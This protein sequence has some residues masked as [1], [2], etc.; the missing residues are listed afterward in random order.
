LALMSVAEHELTREGVFLSKEAFE[1]SFGKGYRSY[2]EAVG[3]YEMVAL[4]LQG[5]PSMQ[6]DLRY[7][8]ALRSYKQMIAEDLASN[9][10]LQ[11]YLQRANQ[12]AG[13]AKIDPEVILASAYDYTNARWKADGWKAA[14]AKARMLKTKLDEGADWGDTLEL[15]S[16]FWDPPMPE[17]GQKP[18][19]GFNFKGRFGSH[20]RNQFVG[21]LSES[22][23][24]TFTT[25]RCIADKIFFEQPGGTISEVLEGEKGFYIARVNSRSPASS[26]LNLAQPDNREFLVTMV[27]LSR[28]GA[29]AGQLLP[30]A[31]STGDVT[32]F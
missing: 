7:E 19:F 1:E 25:G 32:G 13:A 4:V 11:P 28:F 18:P 21:D 6:A 12:I 15:H 22:D 5:F 27:A 3:A 23:Y 14:E 20:T 16:D 31:I 30:A 9:E 26:V 10:K 29:F 2:S 8:R 17:V 24:I